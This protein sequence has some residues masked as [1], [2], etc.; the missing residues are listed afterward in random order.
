M[1]MSSVTTALSLKLQALQE[2]IFNGA[3]SIFLYHSTAKT[4]EFT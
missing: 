1:S 3:T 4:S 2:D